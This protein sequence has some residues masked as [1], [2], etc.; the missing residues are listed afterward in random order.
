MVGKKRFIDDDVSPL[1]EIVR[2]EGL[3]I[4]VF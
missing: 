3:E 1:L 4:E 2:R